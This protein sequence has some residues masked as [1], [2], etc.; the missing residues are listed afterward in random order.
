MYADIGIEAFG[1]PTLPA[2]APSTD[3]VDTNDDRST[4]TTTIRSK[5][6]N[7]VVTVWNT[8]TIQ[9]ITRW[10][11]RLLVVYVVAGLACTAA[12]LVYVAPRLLTL[13]INTVT[14]SWYT[15]TLV[16]FVVM[17]LMN[18]KYSCKRRPTI[19]HINSFSVDRLSVTNARRVWNATAWLTPAA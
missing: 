12:L 6:A 16:T 11:L 14:I 19:V 4:E 13:M 15:Y 1:G 5:I 18:T 17:Q 2:P 3:T 8:G 10:A 9:T 7:I